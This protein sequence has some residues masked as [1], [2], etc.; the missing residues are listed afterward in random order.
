MDKEK[1]YCGWCGK[2]ITKEQY[3]QYHGNCN[4]EHEDAQEQC[5]MVFNP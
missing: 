4:E 3:E 1:Y 5:A 2:E